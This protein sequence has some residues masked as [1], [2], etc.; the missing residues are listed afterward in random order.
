MKKN[1]G[2]NGR[3]FISGLF[4]KG[5]GGERDFPVQLLYGCLWLA[6]ITLTLILFTF[7]FP[8]FFLM[9]LGFFGSK[10]RVV[11][12]DTVQSETIIQLP[13][14]SHPPMINPRHEFR[15]PRLRCH[16][17]S[18]PSR[19]LFFVIDFFLKR[20]GREWM[21]SYSRP[22]FPFFM[23]FIFL[24]WLFLLFLLVSIFGRW[25]EGGSA[26]EGGRWLGVVARLKCEWEGTFD[27]CHC[28]RDLLRQ[29]WFVWILM[30][31]ELVF[32]SLPWN[33]VSMLLFFMI[34]FSS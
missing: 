6:E 24:V 23:R 29:I 3:S 21:E 27:S 31:N 8:L 33:R 13:R 11:Q 14:N 17:G 1:T 2:M 7:V 18:I 10:C 12:S 34:R 16:I 4:V 32:S 26:D 25:W 19:T 5:L 28:W 22:P 15:T 20:E 9:G 30:R